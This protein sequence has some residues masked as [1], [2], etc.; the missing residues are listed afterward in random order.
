M[1]KLSIHSLGTVSICLRGLDMSCRFYIMSAKGDNF[2]DL[3]FAVL[4]TVSIG[5]K[6]VSCKVDPF[7]EGSRNHFESLKAPS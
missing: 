6:F 2:C 1:G 5:S 3:L 4:R 7:S